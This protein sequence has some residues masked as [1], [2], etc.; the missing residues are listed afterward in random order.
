MHQYTLN[1]TREKDMGRPSSY[2]PEV[3]DKICEELAEGGKSLVAI[4][5]ELGLRYATVMQWLS[6]DPEFADKYARARETGI[7]ADFDN[8]VGLAS[9]PPPKVKGF[10]DAGWVSWQKNLVEA[11]KWTLSKRAPKK[12]GDKLD[13][14]VGGSLNVTN[15]TEEELDAK[16]AALISAESGT[17]GAAG[18]ETET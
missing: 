5:K 7:D 15:L 12:Y 9:N 10:T 2:T 13:L 11:H 16:L 18:G 14:N 4:C 8:L 6:N 3:G 1:T 17:P